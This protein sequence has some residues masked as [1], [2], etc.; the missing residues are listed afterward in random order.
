VK[1]Q[2]L[3]AASMNMAVFWDDASCS[4]V[5]TDRGFRDPYC[6]HHPGGD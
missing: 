4:L 3:T 2:L 5:E 6:P 1:F